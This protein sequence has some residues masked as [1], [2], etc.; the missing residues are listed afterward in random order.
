MPTEVTRRGGWASTVA[1][2]ACLTLG[3]AM[4]GSSVAAPEAVDRV[5]G[6]VRIA[7]GKAILG[8]EL[9]RIR[10][11]DGGRI[12]DLKSC[13]DEFVEIASYRAAGSLP[14]YAAHNLCGGDIILGWDVGQ[15]V[16]VE[17]RDTLYEVV[18][19]RTLPK[20]SG[21]DQLE[22]MA[23][24]LILQTCWYG[25]PRMRFMSLAPTTG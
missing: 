6:G 19:E 7:A 12:A 13:R 9:P 3:F 24:D 14:L 2:V 23:G 20:W 15:R 25:V 22:G 16:R 4:V 8:D 10:L 1:I 5:I 21:S 17:G 11:R 18:E